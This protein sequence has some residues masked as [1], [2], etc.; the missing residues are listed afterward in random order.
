[1]FLLWM[2]IAVPLVSAEPI[3]SL[4]DTQPSTHLPAISAPS[5]TDHALQS[6]PVEVFRGIASWYSESDPNINLYTANGE[7]FDDAQL[8]CASWDFPFGTLLKVE[9]LSNGKSV[10]CR[11]NDRGPSKRLGRVIDLTKAAFRRIANPSK[12]LIRVA[13]S[14]ISD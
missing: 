9:N 5:K 4:Q 13:V 6:V 7:F 2:W 1:M 3:S 10:V 11:V 12:G 14:P 8:T